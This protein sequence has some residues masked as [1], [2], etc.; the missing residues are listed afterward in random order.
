MQISWV[1]RINKDHS[2]RVGQADTSETVRS[3][4]LERMRWKN[5]WCRACESCPPQL[6][7]RA[8]MH[9]RRGTRQLKRARRSMRRTGTC[10]CHIPVFMMG[11]AV[12]NGRR[13]AKRH[14]Q[15]LAKARIYILIK[16]SGALVP[17]CR[18]RPEHVEENW[19]L[20]PRRFLMLTSCG[21]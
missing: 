17:R 8:L 15:T 12:M 13:A 21:K 20:T 19:L 14:R 5:G 16:R 18:R 6:P 9:L 1:F 11:Y 7:S 4:M 10:S 2:S 3:A